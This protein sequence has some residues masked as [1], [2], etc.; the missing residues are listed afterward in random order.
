[1]LFPRQIHELPDAVCGDG[2]IQH[3]GDGADEAVETPAETAALLKKEGHVAVENLTVPEPVQTVAEGS[4]GD[5]GG[6]QRQE[7]A[8]ADLKSVIIE[9]VVL[10]ALLPGAELFRI[11]AEHA[12]GLDHVEIEKSLHLKGHHAG[13]EL[14]YAFAVFLHAAHDPAAHHQQ[15]GGGENGN[16]G[17]DGIHPEEHHKG[18]DKGID[19]DD[20]IRNPVD[21]VGCNGPDITVEAVEQIPAGIAAQLVPARVDD[22]V[23]NLGLDVIADIDGN[24][25]EDP[26]VQTGKQERESRHPQHDAQEQ[27]E[28]VPLLTHDDV[29]ERP[30]QPGRTDGETGTEDPDQRI[31]HDDPSVLPGEAENPFPV[32]DEIGEGA[33]VEPPNELLDR[34]AVKQPVQAGIVFCFFSLRSGRVFIGTG[35]IRLSALPV[36]HTAPSIREKN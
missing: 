11:G 15:E 20:E 36:H 4:H 31:E 2:G 18:D 35:M 14:E 12:E 7:N 1:M 25:G 6:N 28:L 22:P 26:A 13:V 24:A 9:A 16:P 19:V 21:G 5:G 8:G 3:A 17:H 23:K 27:P 30:A 32:V 29:D 34:V 10:V 33:V